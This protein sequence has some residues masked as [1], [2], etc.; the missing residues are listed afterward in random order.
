MLYIRQPQIPDH[1][2]IDRLSPV[3]RLY[4]AQFLFHKRLDQPGLQRL[5]MDPAE[6]VEKQLLFL[7]RAGLI[8]ERAGRIFELDRYLYIHLKHIIQ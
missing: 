3:T 6:E 2:V 8:N 4:L 1:A 7:K 5:T